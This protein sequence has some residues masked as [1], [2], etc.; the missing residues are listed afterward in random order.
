MARKAG[1]FEF[2]F[3]LVWLGVGLWIAF[4][5]GTAITVTCERDTGVAR[6]T[7]DLDE[8]LFSN[9]TVYDDVRNVRVTETK[10]KG[11]I[12]YGVA[13]RIASGREDEVIKS[14]SGDEARQAERWFAN[15]EARVVIARASHRTA[16][17]VLI[18]VV[19]LG[20]GLLSYIAWRR[21]K[22]PPA[23]P[24]IVVCNIRPPDQR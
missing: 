2:V 15:H 4:E 14:I 16:S 5:L 10:K 24:M 12:H 6:C 13:V 3:G 7:V 20:L 8:L 9:T 19:V 11:G 23:D 1:M 22:R 21:S 17:I 18:I